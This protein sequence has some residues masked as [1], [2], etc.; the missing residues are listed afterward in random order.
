MLSAECVRMIIMCS[1]GSYLF[2]ISGINLTISFC[3]SPL[4]SK[5]LAVVPFRRFM[6]S[7]WLHYFIQNPFLNYCFAL[8]CNSFLI[9]HVQTSG[10]E[11][12]IT[13]SRSRYGLYT[14]MVYT[15]QYIT[16]QAILYLTFFTLVVY[17]IILEVSTKHIVNTY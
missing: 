17:Y 1:H 8:G 5:N 13:C 9:P 4:S 14:K 6:V 11:L 16:A 12:E 7:N 3:S 10:I 2:Q 15:R